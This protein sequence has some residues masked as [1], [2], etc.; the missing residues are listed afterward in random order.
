[1][2]SFHQVMTGGLTFQETVCH[3]YNPVHMRG[4]FFAVSH[5]D[6]CQIPLSVETIKQGQNLI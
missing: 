6:D 5:N 1:L 3:P 2:K 4:N